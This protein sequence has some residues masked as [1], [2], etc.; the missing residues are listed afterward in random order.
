MQQLIKDWFLSLKKESFSFQDLIGQDTWIS[1]TPTRTSWTDVGTPTVAAR[2]KR[3][4]RHCYFQILVTPETTC[5]T[6]AGTSYT[7]LPIPAAGLAGTGSMGLSPNVAIGSI[8]IDVANSRCYVPTQAATA[9][10]FTIA[11][12]YEI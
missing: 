11:G 6:T 2:Y 9:S 7:N 12:W 10:S 3:I 5:E 4:G 1:W 8:Q